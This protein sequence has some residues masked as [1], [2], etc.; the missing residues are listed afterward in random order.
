PPPQQPQPIY[1]QGGVAYTVQPQTIIVSPHVVIIKD[2]HTFHPYPEFCPKC[3]RIVTTRVLWVSG[4][5]ACTVD[6][7]LFVYHFCGQCYFFFVHQHSKM[8]IIIALVVSPY[9]P[10]K[11]DDNN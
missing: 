7:L 3:Q 9:L 11:G 2:A 5:C 4:S 6:S 10:S 1:T 8:H